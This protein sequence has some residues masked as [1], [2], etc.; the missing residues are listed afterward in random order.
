MI[1]VNSTG[2]ILIGGNST[3]YSGTK[4]TASKINVY[5]ESGNIVVQ[6]KLSGAT[7]VR[8]I[9]LKVQ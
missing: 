1:S 4:D 6:N 2:S 8:T 5:Y 3:N 7:T 9:V